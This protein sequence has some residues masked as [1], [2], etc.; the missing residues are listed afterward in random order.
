VGSSLRES[1][2]FLAEAIPTPVAGL[3]AD[4]GLRV[5][6]VDHGHI[7]VLAA[8]ANDLPPIVVHRSSMQVVDG[9]HR[10]R[11]AQVRGEAEIRAVFVDGDHVDALVLAIRLNARHGL[12]LTRRDRELAVRRLLRARPEWSDRRI[13]G[14]SGV[15]HKTVGKVRQRASGEIPQSHRLGADG[16]MRPRDPVERRRHAAALLSERPDASARE[17][18]RTVGLSPATVLD[19]KRRRAQGLDPAE[20]SGWPERAGVGAAVLL[21]PDPGRDLEFLRGD[22]S[23]RYSLVGRNLLRFLHALV[24]LQEPDQVV[25]A[26]PPHSRA[27]L[28]RLARANARYWRRIADELDLADHEDQARAGVP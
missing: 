28:A 22:P 6:G 26:V 5:S 4:L 17:I 13:A 16:R 19:V 7:A 1:G 2:P 11:A 20:S 23:L 24:T 27:A 3:R 10:L 25:P 12:P 8:L 18:A 14:L 9:T 15:S 21:D